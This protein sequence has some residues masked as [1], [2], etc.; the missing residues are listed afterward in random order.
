MCLIHF[1]WECSNFQGADLTKVFFPGAVL[2][3]VFYFGGRFDGGDLAK[4]RFVCD[5]S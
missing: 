2:T 5:S 3:R 4:G 1:L